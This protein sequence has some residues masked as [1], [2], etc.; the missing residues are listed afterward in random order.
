MKEK[1]VVDK[2]LILL[3]VLIPLSLGTIFYYIF[4]PEVFFVKCI[5]A[6]LGG[7]YHVSLSDMESVV[8]GIIR[9]HV[10]DMLWAYALVF[11][12]FCV[13][14]N[15]ETV[16][17][18]SFG[19]AIFFS[20]LME[21]LQITSFVKGTFDMWDIVLAFVAEGVAVLIIKIL[22]RRNVL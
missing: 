1:S 14:G 18:K 9:N 8:L 22:L 17:L 6:L 10:L 19:I 12:V 21:L 20:L 7:G 4:S 13:I 15:N 5:D 16:L 2:K 3:N 11:A